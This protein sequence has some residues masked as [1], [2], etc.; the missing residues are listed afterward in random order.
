MLCFYI[1][2]NVTKPSDK[3]V[4]KL[5]ED[6]FATTASQVMAQTK[7]SNRVSGHNKDLIQQSVLPTLI[8]IVK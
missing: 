3:R 7:K 1:I 4:R 5:M 6:G 2:E 8:S